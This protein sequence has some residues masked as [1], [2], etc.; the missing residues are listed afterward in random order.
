MT[1][2]PREF[3]ARLA[4]ATP[5]LWVTP[6]L[7]G[8]NVA[9]WIANIADGLDPFSPLAAELLDWGA[10][11]AMETR[12]QP[13]RLLSAAF[14]HGGLVHLAVNMWAL[15][16]AGRLVERFFGNMQFLL[17]Y[18]S[19][20]VF[21]SLASLYSTAQSGVAVGASGAV[22]GAIGG[23]LSALFASRSR[24]PPDLA[25]PLGRSMLAFTGFALLLGFASEHV[26]NAAH[27]GGLVTGAALGLLLARR[28]DWDRYTAQALPRAAL[29]LALLIGAGWLLWRHVPTAS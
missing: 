9:T 25:R 28:F 16:D 20:G 10:N 14:L 24:I 11:R 4:R 29:A 8:L 23:L 7:I 1:T 27:V 21:G 18:L 6:L 15:R 22:F 26:D 12:G 3:A 13:W 19:S 2:D 17:I 5:R